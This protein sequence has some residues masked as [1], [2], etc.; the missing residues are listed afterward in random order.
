MSKVIAIADW[1]DPHNINHI[2]AWV[3]LKK[4]GAWPTGFIP[5]HVKM[6]SV[7]QV[8][9]AWKLAEAWVDHITTSNG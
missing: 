7:W 9:V 8:T 4:H 5:N 6:D 2:E 3:H 1:F